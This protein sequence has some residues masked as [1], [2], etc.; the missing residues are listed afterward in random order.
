[1]DQQRQHPINLRD[2]DAVGDEVA[3]DSA[4]VGAW[5]DAVLAADGIGYAPPGDYL[6]GSAI[7]RD[8]IDDKR[9]ALFGAGVGVTRF[10]VP[11]TNTPS[12]GR[13]SPRRPRAT[14]N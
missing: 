1:V 12:A 3:D 8:G 9:L 6:L 13:C 4:A 11:V 2:F 7:V 5:I 10:I 14:R